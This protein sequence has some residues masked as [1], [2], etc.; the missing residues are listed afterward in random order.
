VVV[1][2]SKYDV[3][4]KDR[5]EINGRLG[6]ALSDLARLEQQIKDQNTWIDRLH[7]ELAGLRTDFMRVVD[8]VGQATPGQ[9]A[10]TL[11]DEDP[12]KEQKEG[13]PEY[14]TPD[15]EEPI[16]VPAIVQSLD[17]PTATAQ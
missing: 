1:L 9:M 13:P 15:A 4:Q 7:S 5:D 10:R 17:E 2:R 3:L 8:R 14:L 16:D 12:F 11:F 6:V